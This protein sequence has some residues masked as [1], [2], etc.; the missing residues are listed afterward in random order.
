M[1]YFYRIHGKVLSSWLNSSRKFH[2]K[3]LTDFPRREPTFLAKNDFN[4]RPILRGRA[5]G[6]HA[7]YYGHVMSRNVA[8]ML[9]ILLVSSRFE[10]VEL[11][12]GD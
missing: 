4:R 10:G 11:P 1:R 12:S 9:G 6:V 3:S 8:R 2:F 7:E 5:Y